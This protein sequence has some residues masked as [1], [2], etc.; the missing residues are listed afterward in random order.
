MGDQGLIGPYGK[1]RIGVFWREQAPRSAL[2]LGGSV[3]S[4][5]P[6]WAREPLISLESA[7][8]LRRYRVF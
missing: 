5:D 2:F 4:S 1:P 3:S 8:I 7:S 6:P